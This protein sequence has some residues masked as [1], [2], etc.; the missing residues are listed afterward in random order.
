MHMSNLD[1]LS[2][3]SGRTTSVL[4][5]YSTRSYM[6]ENRSFNLKTDGGRQQSVRK[7]S[8]KKEG[9]CLC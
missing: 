5:I 4:R 7:H 8:D 3:I 2:E 1:I 9:R 6:M